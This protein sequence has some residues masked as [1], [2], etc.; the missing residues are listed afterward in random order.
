MIG[1]M[2]GKYQ[3]VVSRHAGHC[4]QEDQPHETAEAL[5]HFWERNEKSVPPG[6]KKVGQR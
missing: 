1:Q 3:L 6:L 2:Q 5:V 4:V